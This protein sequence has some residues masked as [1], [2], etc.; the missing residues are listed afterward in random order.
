MYDMLI[1]GGELLDGTGQ[2]SF[3]SDVGIKDSKI[4]AI[5]NL[6]GKLP[7]ERL[8]ASGLIV[9][10]RFIDLTAIPSRR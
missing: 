5:G 7:A 6:S 1:T 10:P 2:P 8:D 3:R 9:A 4:A